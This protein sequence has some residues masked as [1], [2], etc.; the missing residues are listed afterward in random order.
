M[1]SG[2]S[3][4]RWIA[5]VSVPTI[6]SVC[7][8]HLFPNKVATTFNV[9]GKNYMS[10]KIKVPSQPPLYT[11]IGSDIIK[12]DRKRFHIAASVDL[13]DL[14]DDMKEPING[15]P[16]YMIVNVMLPKYEPAN[17]VFGK[18]VTDGENW[19]YVYYTVM[20]R[21]TR[22]ALLDLDNASEAV[23]LLHAFMHDDSQEMRERFKMMVCALNVDDIEVGS[24]VKKLLHQYNMKPIL[25][26][27]QHEFHT[28]G[29]TY[30]EIDIDVNQFG[31][32]VRSSWSSM[33]EKC[34]SM[35]W[36]VG[37]CVE[38]RKAE[39]LPEQMAIV[40]LNHRSDVKDALTVPELVAASKKLREEE[41]ANE[42]QD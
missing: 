27:P 10:D 5:G 39:E 3:E 8:R 11:P 32:L 34:A 37:L 24:V 38:G 19:S 31:Y 22:E 33:K 25:T 28:D 20:T 23:K 13:P 6:S 4:D 42:A 21:E 40:L 41:A 36:D 2:G 35:I 16:A 26:R 12:V 9:R 1:A 7:N 14:P 29:K 30:F 17:P 18:T 15:V